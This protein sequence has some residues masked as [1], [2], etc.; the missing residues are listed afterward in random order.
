MVALYSEY[1]HREF[2]HMYTECNG[3]DNIYVYTGA[4]IYYMFVLCSFLIL[5]SLQHLKYKV[6]ATGKARTVKLE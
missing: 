5:H 3:N 4:G 1:S 6:K 2:F